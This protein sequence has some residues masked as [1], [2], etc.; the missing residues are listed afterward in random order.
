MTPGE[1]RDGLATIQAHINELENA[2]QKQTSAHVLYHEVKHELA[3][4][5][6]A[7][8][9]AIDSVNQIGLRSNNGA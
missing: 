8:E 7:V 2:A 6:E 1:I 5:S 4:A 9:R 3:E